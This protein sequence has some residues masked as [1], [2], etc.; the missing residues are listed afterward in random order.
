MPS[1]V[2]FRLTCFSRYTDHTYMVMTLQKL[3]HLHDDDNDDSDSEYEVDSLGGTWKS[4]RGRFSKAFH[5]MFSKSAPKNKYGDG[6]R[7]DSTAAGISHTN[8]FVTGH[9]DGVST[10]P[11]KKLRTLQG[12]HG[13]VNQER[14]EYMEKQSP[15]TKRG[16]AV[17]AEQ[18]SIF[19]TAGKKVGISHI[20]Y[21]LTWQTTRS[22]RSFNHLL[23]ISNSPSFIA[24]LPPILF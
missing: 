4:K 11:M 13:G 24:W 5:K 3:V 17:S 12:Y 19:L 15:L 6:Q 2:W 8:G 9:T 18:V 7:R 10:A 16:W 21:S 22:F 1:S 14:V 23:T 20:I